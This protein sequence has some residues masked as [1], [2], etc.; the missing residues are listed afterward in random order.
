SFPT[1]HRRPFHPAVQ[2]SAFWHE[3]SKPHGSPFSLPI[4]ITDSV[5]VR[6]LPV[7]THNLSHIQNPQSLF[8][9]TYR[10]YQQ[11]IAVLPNLPYQSPRSCRQMDS[12]SHTL[13]PPV[14]Y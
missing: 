1:G 13:L 3:Q 9:G 4:L 6:I 2:I 11:S 10:K 7:K 8:S 12:E 5:N 14:A